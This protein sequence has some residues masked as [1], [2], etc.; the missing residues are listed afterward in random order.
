MVVV[1][2]GTDRTVFRMHKRII[3]NVS[4]FFKAA[5][6]G[7]FAE[8]QKQVLELPDES[9]AMFKHFQLWVYTDSI[10]AKD[11]AVQDITSHSLAG[12]YIF[13]EK[14]GIPDLQNLAIDV[15]IDKHDIFKRTPIEMIN[16]VY[17]HTPDRAPLR[18][19]LVDFM[20]RNHVDIP[21]LF[22]EQVKKCF[23][24]D[25]LFDL[26][27]VQNA[28]RIGSKNIIDDFK[29]C[30]SNYHVKPTVSPPAAAFGGLAPLLSIG[31]LTTSRHLLSNLTC[32]F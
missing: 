4:P 7:K 21:R 19:L 29:A 6:E 25:F 12:L 20:A 22:V 13:G 15:I 31:E 10:M 1:K 14:C 24:K 16:T 3:C 17:D 18:R 26:A 32:L 11:E 28:L 9:V 2:V 8:A 30:R 5:F 27:I 23:P